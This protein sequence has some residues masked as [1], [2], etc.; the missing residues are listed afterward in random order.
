MF[1]LN[2]LAVHSVVALLLQTCPRFVTLLANRTDVSEDYCLPQLAILRGR[3]TDALS[4]VRTAVL[5]QNLL[6]KSLDK[7]FEITYSTI[8]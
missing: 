4:S 2:I 7:Q 6:A 5:Q 1:R 8:C 3:N